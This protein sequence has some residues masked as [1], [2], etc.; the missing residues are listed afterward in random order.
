LIDKGERVLTL[1]QNDIGSL[2]K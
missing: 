2:F 1:L